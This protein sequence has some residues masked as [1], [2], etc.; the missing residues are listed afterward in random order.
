[1]PANRAFIA[2]AGDTGGMVRDS[3]THREVSSGCTP[4]EEPYRW[5]EIRRA[6]DRQLSEGSPLLALPRTQTDAPV[7]RLSAGRALGQ[8][9]L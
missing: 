4:S 5:A 6:Q 3:S 7:E 8:V 1:M 2:R 9:L